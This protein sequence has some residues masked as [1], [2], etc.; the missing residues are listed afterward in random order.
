MEED[1]PF[2]IAS[3]LAAGLDR[4]A[5]RWG[6]IVPEGS[7][8]WALLALA[9]PQ[10]G[11]SV[12][13]GALDR[14]IGN[15]GSAEQ[16]KSKFLLAGLAGLDRLESGTA[17]SAAG[18]LGV[19]LGRESAWSRMISQAAEV[20]NPTLVVL[21]AG[22]GMQGEGW[23]KMTARQ[24]YHI[25]RSLHRVGLSAEARMIAAEAVARG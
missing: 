20:N 22:L 24:L 1:A 7:A 16:R 18:Q 12:S 17:Q 25:V 11:T 2:L 23:D 13:G 4:N 9:E 19:D 3:M 21:L 10:R 6:Q 5:I 8:G 15:D 14:F